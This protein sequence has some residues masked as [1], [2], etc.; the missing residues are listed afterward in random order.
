MSVAKFSTMVTLSALTSACV[1]PSTAWA[2][3]REHKAKA[4]RLAERAESYLRAQQDKASGGWSVPKAAAPEA[5]PAEPK[6]ADAK[7]A[8]P[9]PAGETKP[10][11]APTRPHMPGI[12]ALVL[13]G[14]LMDDDL[15]VAYAAAQPA[16]DRGVDY[17]LSFQQPDGG[18]YDQVLPNYNTSLALSAL[19]MVDAPK[20]KKAI[21]PMQDCL[22]RLQYGEDSDSTVGGAEAATRVDPSHPFYGGVG[23]GKHSRPDNSNLNM[24]MQ[25]MEDSGVPASDPAV[26]RALVFLAR[27]QMLDEVNDQPYADGSRQGGFVYATA[28]NAESVDQH[29]GQSQA[30]TMEETLSDGTTGSR[31]RSY[32]SM[33]YAGFKSYMYAK[34][35]KSDPRVNAAMGWIRSHY[36]LDE[37]PGMGSDGQYYYYMTFARALKAWGEPVLD[38]KAGGKVERRDWANDLVNK[39]ETLQNDDGSFKPFKDRWMESDPVLITAYGLIALRDARDS[40]LTDAPLEAHPADA[41]K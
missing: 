33:T 27:T 32:G 28:E 38:V 14:L 18:I 24:F 9:K 22:R 31:L 4:E 36:T 16:I 1:L 20:A 8:E 19:A 40:E 37:N 39:L 13:R 34:L 17:L 29:T 7:P 6:P 23:Y 2:I 25:A 10:S 35:E 15:A 5:K 11:S 12:T 3:D 26:Q 41:K 21:K 30:G